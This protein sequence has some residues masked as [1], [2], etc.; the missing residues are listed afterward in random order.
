MKICVI[1]APYDSGHHYAGCGR[2]PAAI[3]AGGLL[4]GLSRKGHDVA[5]EDIGPVGE[6][7]GREIVTGFAV[8]AAIA[9]KV[10]EA[11]QTGRFPVVLAGNCL[12]AVGAV[13]GERAD[14]V[15]WFDQHGD[16]NTPETSTYG[17][18]DGM[19]LAVTLGLCWRPM[20][21]AIPG[22]RPVDPARCVLVDARDLDPDEALLL[23]RLPVTQIPCAEAAGA[24]AALRLEAAGALRTHVHVDLDV[25]D[26]AALRVNR[27]AHPGGPDPDRLRQV[28]CAAAASVPVAGLTLSAY[29]PAF[30]AGG[31]VPE[32]ACRLVVDFVAALEAPAC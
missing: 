6:G 24:G 11:G 17:F 13:A 7:P 25:C 28:V 23:E 22:F 1:T 8:C 3:L 31:G 16:L 30:D 4:E 9:R 2:G 32:A 5:L 12:S 19:A 10:A 29:D 26:P 15:I 14:A 21:N 20:A 27:Y 18:L